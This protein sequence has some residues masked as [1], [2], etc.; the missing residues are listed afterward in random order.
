M[1]MG[2]C[3]PNP[4]KE[5]PQF[6]FR[7]VLPKSFYAVLPIALFLLYFYYSSHLTRP[8]AGEFPN[9]TPVFIPSSVSSPPRHKGDRKFNETPCDYTNGKW[10]PDTLDP[11]YN[12]TSCGTI[13]E[14][15]NCRSHGRP[16]VGYLYWRWKPR[17]C[18]L[19]RFN[20]SAFLAFL[21]NKHLAFVGDSMARNQLESL[22]CMLASFASPTLLYSNG[23][24]S[25]FRRWHFPSH[26]VNISVYWSPFLVKGI[27]K[28]EGYNYNQLYMDFVDE[29][30]ASD[31]GLIDMVVLSIGHWY[32]HPAVYFEGD[33]VLGCHFCPSLNHTEIGFYGVFRKAFRTALEATIQRKGAN[34]NDIDVVV[35]TF[36]PH[37]FEGEWDKAGACPKIL[38]YEEAE[39]VL[40][41]MDEEMR[42]S[43]VE[44][45]EEAKLSAKQH[46]GKIRIAALDVTKLA[47]LRPDGHP[48]P[49]MHRFPFSNGVQD[50]VQ[51]DCVHWCLPGPIDTWNE[52]MMDIMKGWRDQSK[53][54]G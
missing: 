1:K 37:H 17:K 6:L 54:G 52:I 27:E 46:R 13:K 11:L 7:K 38:P 33:R 24:D 9:N 5:K 41:G 43:G 40:E 53:D 50:R 21:G 42:R 3:S 31:L 35:T 4:L 8:P 2:N 28:H 51:N 32:L 20:P 10:V 25:E 23:D 22:L 16:D 49:Y 12:D 29:R 48:G 34:G 45:V 47:M 36:S 26:N 15:R 39:R 44:E 19:P 14:G 18:E 30:W